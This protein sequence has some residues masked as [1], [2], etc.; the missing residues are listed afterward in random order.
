MNLDKYFPEEYT[1]KGKNDTKIKHKIYY[2]EKFAFKPK[3]LADDRLI[4]HEIEPDAELRQVIRNLEKRIIGKKISFEEITPS[5]SSVKRKLR[6][7]RAEYPNKDND[8]I[9]DLIDTYRSSLKTRSKE[10]IKAIV[11]ILLLPDYIIIVNAKKDP[12]L[13][14]LD[15]KIRTVK[16]ILH[17]KNVLRADIIKNTNEGLIF[18]SFSY[19]KKWTKGHAEF[20]GI[21]PDYISWENLGNISFKIELNNYQYTIQQPLESSDIDNLISNKKLTSTGKIKIGRESGRILEVM[22]FRKIMSFKDFYNFYIIEKQKIRKFVKKFEEIHKALGEIT[23]FIQNYRYE[24]EIDKIYE[25]L[26]NERSLFIK[27]ENP[28]FII[29]FFS[30]RLKIKPNHDLINLIY[31]AIFENNTIEIVHVGLK[32]S[33]DPITI[34]CLQIYNKIDISNEILEFSE[35]FLDI[36]QDTRSKKT[37]FLLQYCYCEFWK[38]LTKEEYLLDMFDFL[39]QLIISEEINYEFE[40]EGICEAEDIIDFKSADAF[41]PKLARFVNDRLIPTIDG[42]FDGEK[43]TRYCILYGIEDNGVINPIYHFKSDFTKDIENKANEILTEM[44]LSISAYPIPFKRETILAIFIL[45]RK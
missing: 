8:I 32:P 20:W 19:S 10:K 12:S 37:K 13:A 16:I 34:G 42:Y 41:T 14:E 9:E 5:N 40:S 44:K 30:K 22:V 38:K 23:S 3:S 39:I 2:W 36:I 17:P 33:D 1:S 6:R 29:C 31:R 28:R 24:E 15:D 35:E 21:D 45:P 26:P 11:S 18:S 4:F 43:L 25:I 7:V 27:K